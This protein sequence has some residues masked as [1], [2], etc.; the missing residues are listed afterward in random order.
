MLTIKSFFQFLE[1][2]CSA[3]NKSNK[4]DYNVRNI[5]YNNVEE[6]KNSSRLQSSTEKKKPFKLTFQ[7]QYL[8]RHQRWNV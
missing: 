5:A 1:L 8:I 3:V 4:S 7:T 6:A 2:G